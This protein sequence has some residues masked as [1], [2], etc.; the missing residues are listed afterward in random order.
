MSARHVLVGFEPRRRLLCNLPEREGGGAAIY[1]TLPC[2]SRRRTGWR[3]I[4]SRI[5][6][7]LLLQGHWRLARYG[8]AHR[9][10]T[11]TASTAW[12]V[13]AG[14]AGMKRHR[15]LAKATTEYLERRATG[16]L[17]D[18]HLHLHAGPLPVGRWPAHLYGRR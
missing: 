11:L 7:G 1:H 4:V 17:A 14:D 13:R 3:E 8:T 2:Q 15:P 18:L 12:H 5:S 10:P 6:A 9:D 16:S